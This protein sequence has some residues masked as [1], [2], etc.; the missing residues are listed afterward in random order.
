MVKLAI[1]FLY[2]KCDDLTRFSLSKLVES[3]PDAVII[4]LTDSV[5][6]HL[7]GTVDVSKFPSNWVVKSPWE[8]I[9]VTVYRWFENRTLDAERYIF[10]EYDCLCTVNLMEHYS[11]V[12]QADIAGADLFTRSE[13]PKW[14]FF[15]PTLIGD[16]SAKDRP[17]AAGLVPF[18]GTMF[19]H[20]AL[21]TFVSK[22]DR[23]AIFCELRIGTT[24]NRLG[25][26]YQR[27]PLSMRQTLCWH[28]YPWKVNSSG[29]FHAIKSLDY[30]RGR[31]YQPGPIAAVV[32]DFIRSSDP[33]RQFTSVRRFMK[34]RLLKVWVHLLKFMS[35]LKF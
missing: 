8:N 33:N 22:V 3:N 31:R 32:Y 6:E 27:F 28:E 24:I 7:P 18:V 13:N 11:S 34:L 4:P 21:A 20:D 5:S 19:S 30:N 26:K 15:N 25:L 2:H 16:L 10:I 29:L 35:Q 23:S 14:A 12:W 1:L 17:F 9:D